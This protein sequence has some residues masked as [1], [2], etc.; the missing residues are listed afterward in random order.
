VQPLVQ[1][2]GTK[3]KI[4][5]PLVQIIGKKWARWGWVLPGVLV[6]L[7]KSGRR[8]GFLLFGKY[9]PFKK[10]LF[11]VRCE[12]LFVCICVCLGGA[13]QEWE[14]N[15]FVVEF[16]VCVIVCVCVCGGGGFCVLL[17]TNTREKLEI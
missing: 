7:A 12:W 5:I 16:C 6:V 17:L 10:Q 8:T 9:V 4:Q 13:S 2:C 3:A 1:I 15:R 14:G 11:E